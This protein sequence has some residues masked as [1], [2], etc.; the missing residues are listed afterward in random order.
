MIKVIL[1]GLIA[2]AFAIG[3]NSMSPKHLRISV[4]AFML[5]W[6]GIT[7]VTRRLK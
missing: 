2:A 4:L 3:I 7:Y 5:V 1:V 6:M